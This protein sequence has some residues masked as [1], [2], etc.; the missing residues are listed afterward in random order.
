MGGRGLNLI[1]LNVALENND[2]RL[3][4]VDTRDSFATVNSRPRN[5]HSQ[6]RGVA[7][8][9]R[10][11]SSLKLLAE[12]VCLECG[13]L[14]GTRGGGAPM[15]ATYRV[16]IQG[17]AGAGFEGVRD[18]FAENFRGARDTRPEHGTHLQ[19]N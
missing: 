5:G 15:T 6:S 12:R 4:R 14:S 19:R 10:Q 3:V 2:R 13:S 9:F 8:W 7:F 11:E 1:R 18:A 16:D 17:R